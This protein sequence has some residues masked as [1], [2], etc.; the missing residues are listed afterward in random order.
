M[1]DTLMCSKTRVEH[2]KQLRAMFQFLKDKQLIVMSLFELTHKGHALC[3]IPNVKIVFKTL[4]VVCKDASKVSLS[5]VLMLRDQI[6]TWA[7]RQLKTYE[8]NYPIMIWI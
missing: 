7:P 5:Y 6:V 3:M 4:R 2:A 1:E 8:G